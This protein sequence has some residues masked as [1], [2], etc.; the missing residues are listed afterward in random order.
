M[1]LGLVQSIDPPLEGAADAPPFRNMIA[2]ESFTLHFIIDVIDAF[3]S[4]CN[5]DS[6][7]LKGSEHSSARRRWRTLS[8]TGRK[9]LRKYL[10]VMQWANKWLMT[11]MKNKGH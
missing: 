6:C 10:F 1:S 8:Q 3:L 11:K 2:I 4:Y 9:R 7:L 5:F